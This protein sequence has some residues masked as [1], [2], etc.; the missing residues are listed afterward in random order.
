MIDDFI[1]SRLHARPSLV[2]GLL[3]HDKKRRIATAL[4]R[5]RKAK[6]LT[7][8][9]VAERAGWGQPFVS[10]LEKLTGEAPEEKTIQRYVEACGLGVETVYYVYDAT[11]EDRAIIAEI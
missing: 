8:V 4:R 1:Q 11:T 2:E 10:K 7:Q 6:G 3:Q 9:Q 5:I